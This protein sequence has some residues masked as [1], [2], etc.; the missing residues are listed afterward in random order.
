LDFWF[1]NIPSGNPVS[2]HWRGFTFQLLITRKKKNKCDKAKMKQVFCSV[3]TPGLPDD[4]FS[5]P[6][7]QFG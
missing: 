4:L 7:S 3:T 1:E 5:N 6:K 2:Q